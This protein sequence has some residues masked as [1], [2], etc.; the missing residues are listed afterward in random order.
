EHA[1]DALWSIWFRSA[2]DVH[3]RELQRVIR[4]DVN[5]ERAESVIAQFDALA[6]AAP[7]FAEVFNQRAIVHFRLGEFSKSVADCEKTLRLTPLP[8]GAAGGMARAFL[9]QRKPRAALRSY[10]KAFR[11]NPNIDGI[12]D[13]I[14]SLKKTLGEEGKR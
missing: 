7:R 1:A 3:V 12:S 9:K 2:D 11:I 6:K 4:L 10:R 14:N 13:A 5:P 8:L